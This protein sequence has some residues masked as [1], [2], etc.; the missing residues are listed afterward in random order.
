MTTPAANEPSETDLGPP[1]LP[2]NLGLTA[3]GFATEEEARELGTAVLDCI[4]LLSR[5]FNLS[6]LDGVTVAHDYQQALATLD[7]GYETKH[8]L[9]PSD[10]HANCT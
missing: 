5:H 4:R 6:R 8:I 9:T 7:R 3:R 2:E 10:G 1:T